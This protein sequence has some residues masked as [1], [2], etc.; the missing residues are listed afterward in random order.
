MNRHDT[1]AKQCSLSAALKLDEEACADGYCE[2]QELINYLLEQDPLAR[3]LKEF[4]KLKLD[5]SKGL[6]G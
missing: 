5:G 3:K 2:K 6:E 1:C 4:T